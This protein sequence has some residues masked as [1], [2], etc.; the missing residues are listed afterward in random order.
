MISGLNVGIW[1]KSLFFKINKWNLCDLT[2]LPIE[3]ATISSDERQL[4]VKE[5]YCN[6]G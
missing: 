1:Y 6:Q 3:L 2:E 4:I 5:N